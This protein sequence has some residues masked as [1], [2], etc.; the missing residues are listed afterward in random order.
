MAF[1]SDGRGR[2]AG[3]GPEGQRGSTAGV[4]IPIGVGLGVPLGLVLDNLALGI[5]IG[6]AIGVTIGFAVE[7]RRK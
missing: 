3:E 5:A 1:E 2:P 7:R 4:W 6:A